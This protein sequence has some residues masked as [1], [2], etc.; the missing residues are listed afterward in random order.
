V[1]SQIDP[2]R[3]RA[4]Q[5]RAEAVLRAGD[6]PEAEDALRRAQVRLR[7]ATGASASASH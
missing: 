3:A 7:A 1:S 4:A 6:D 2:E 5:E